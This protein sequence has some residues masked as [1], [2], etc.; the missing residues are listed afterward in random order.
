MV[1]ARPLGLREGRVAVLAV[2]VASLLAVSIGFCGPTA[3]ANPK[4]PRPLAKVAVAAD[5]REVTSTSKITPAVQRA[6]GKRQAVFV[7]LKGS[8]AA[9]VSASRQAA[10]GSRAAARAASKARRLE[11]AKTSSRVTAAARSADPSARVLFATRDSVPGVGLLTT[12]TAVKSLAKRSDV[13]KISLLSKH[14]ADNAGVARLTKTLNVWQNLGLTG[15]GIR[16]GVI[17]TGIDYTHADFGGPGT[18]AA[19]EAARANTASWTPT[20]KV[21]GGYD[22]AGDDYNADP[23]DQ[24]YQPTPHPDP[25]PLDCAGHGSHV[26]GTAA[27]FGVNAD[28]STFTGNYSTL[29]GSAL[30]GMRIGPGMAPKAL[31]YAYRIFGCEGSTDLVI[32]AMDRALDPNG[33]G[34]FSD[35]LDVLNMSLGGA[36]SPADDPETAVV[37]ELTANGVMVVTSAGND[38]DLTDAGGPPGNA[39]TALATASGKDEYEP[40]S[41]KR[42]VPG[43]TDTVSSFSS[44]GVHG[45]PGVVKPD[46]TGVGQTVVSARVGTGSEASILSGTSMASPGVAGIAALVR[47]RHPSWTPEQVKAAIMN[48]AVHDLFTGKNHT[49]LRY[50][51]NRVGAGRVDAAYATTTSVL[52]YNASIKGAVSVSFGA[53]EAPATRAVVHKSQYVRIQNTAGSP[54]VVGL[55]YAPVLRQ[56]GVSYSVSPSAVSLRGRSS[57]LVK[58][59]MTVVTSR[60]RKTKD[61]TMTT[62]QVNGLSGVTEARQ[63]VSDA[64]GRLLVKPAGKPALRVPVYGAAKPASVTH[65]VSVR[66]TGRQRAIEL[67]GR[68]FDQGSGSS[69][70]ES[71]VSVLTHGYTSGKVAACVPPEVAGCV[72]NASSRSA[73]LR[74][75]GA[76]AAPDSTGSRE[77]GY[78]WF[79][80]ATWGNWATIGYTT[81]PF[82]D[83]DVDADGA[84][85]YEAFVDVVPETDLVIS[86]LVDSTGTP[87]SY[88]PVNFLEGDADSNVFDTNTLLLPVDPAK[89]GLTDA[90]SSYPIRYRIG[91]GSDWADE[92]GV[93]DLTPWIG[94]DVANP[95]VQVDSPLYLDRHGTVIPYSL[96]SG[97]SSA[98]RVV[99]N[100]ATKSNAAAVKALLLHLHGVSRHKAGL[101]TLRR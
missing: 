80:L 38:G 70:F 41:F 15:S 64:S 22:F 67:L 51:P 69:A 30:Y 6:V 88:Y 26:A 8:G 36:F 40:Q 32:P 91:M 81:T 63:Y 33:D 20:A 45:R 90:D 83:I 96:A 11:V 39:V 27:G 56:P 54:T 101:V 62:T 60:L 73:D 29:T 42:I 2:A 24:A 58:L 17:D 76:G 98:S 66:L 37:D 61:P 97:S 92:T 4:T 85:D 48:T 77:T 7:Q 31:L 16:I 82:V 34:D 13:A 55:R 79:G 84:F 68:G 44:R 23:E 59:T 78:L 25:N 18:V 89:I 12:K 93:F 95:A 19:Y 49:G 14:T 35:H 65:G 94:F 99:D 52:A 28:G 3:T 43:L 75:V 74:Y 100:A 53:V 72:S 71:K 46:V 87:L 1:T 47:K 10:G 21:V 50:G 86:L 5:A 57:R 9:D